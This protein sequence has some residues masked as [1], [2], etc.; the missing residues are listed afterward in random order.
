M[1]P[2]PLLAA[3]LFFISTSAWAEGSIR[4]NLAAAADRLEE[5][6]ERNQR[7]SRECRRNVDAG[8]Y[9][10][11]DALDALRP[12]DDPAKFDTVA[13]QLAGNLNMAKLSGCPEEVTRELTRGL[14]ELTD[15]Q[16]AVRRR[17]G[18][19]P[20][21]GAPPPPPAQ[22]G[23]VFGPPD[24][25]EAGGPGPVIAIPTVTI[26]GFQN[27]SVYLAWHWKAENGQWSQ[28]ESLPAVAVNSYQFV[29]NNPYRQVLDYGVLRQVDTGGRF[30]VHAGVFDMNGREIQGV[31]LPFTAH[32]PGSSPPPG[33]P[34]PGRV[35]FQ[36]VRGN[37]PPPPPPPGQAVMA[38]DCGTGLDD[39]GCSMTRGGDLPM[40][41]VTFEGFVQGL[42][43]NLSESSR[44]SMVRDT[45][46]AR[47][48]TS[49]QLGAMMDLFIGENNRLDAARFSASHVVDPNNAL[50]FA[51]KFNSASRQREY[52][53]LI[54]AQR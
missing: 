40:D 27:S 19:P 38:R 29:W 52:S 23:V 37:P 39:P 11:V 21:P 49:R 8:L 28:W 44:G 7:S 15:A 18:P 36:P 25:S 31:D 6:L 20:P 32:Y 24:I 9:Q 2:T 50:G 42:R 45:M 51:T 35:V 33:G 46:R 48:I 30:V 34:P 5:A 12:S 13:S 41:R 43:A 53:Q 22:P 47:F 4:K 1:R 54:S 16:D 26:T 14:G 3:V 17:R 10:L